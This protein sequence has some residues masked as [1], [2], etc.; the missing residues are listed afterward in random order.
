MKELLKET[1]Q[2]KHL[3]RSYY[4][5]TCKQIKPCG[6][7]TSGNYCCQCYFQNEKEKAQEYSDYQQVYQQKRKEQKER[8]Q[9]LGLLKDYLGCPKCGSKEIDAYS[10]YENNRLICQPCL[11]KKEGGSSGAVSFSERQK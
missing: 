8:F 2:Q 10:L 7:L 5:S 11:I 4:C 3:F 6:V 9:Q 1:N